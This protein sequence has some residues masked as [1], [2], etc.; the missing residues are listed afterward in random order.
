MLEHGPLIFVAM[1]L[2]LTGIQF[3]SVG[4]I[5]EMLARTYYESQKKPI[6]ALREIKGRR[7]EAALR[8]EP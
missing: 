1:L 4:L 2:F 8:A 6:Y 5:A 7:S 3:L